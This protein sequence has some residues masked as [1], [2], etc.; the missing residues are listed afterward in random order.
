MT[1][2]INKKLYTGCEE[3]EQICP[4]NLLYQPQPAEIEG[5][6]FSLKVSQ[7]E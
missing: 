1:I 7:K 2:K 3:Y 4:V 5:K 6:R